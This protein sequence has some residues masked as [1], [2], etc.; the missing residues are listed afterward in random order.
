MTGRQMPR[1]GA[2]GNGGGL[3]KAAHGNVVVAVEWS[4]EPSGCLTLIG[5]SRGLFVG[6][7]WVEARWVE[8]ALSAPMGSWC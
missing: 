7:H 3:V 4:M 1:C 6:E 2:V 5:G 8:H